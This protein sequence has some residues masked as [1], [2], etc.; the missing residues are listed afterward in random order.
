MSPS[1]YVLHISS[2]FTNISPLSHTSPSYATIPLRQTNIWTPKYLIMGRKQ[3]RYS[4]RLI[5]EK[6]APSLKSCNKTG[7][8]ETESPSHSKSSPTMLQSQFIGPIPLKCQPHE[9]SEY[10]STSQY[11]SFQYMLYSQRVHSKYFLMNLMMVKTSGNK[12]M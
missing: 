4:S 1:L 11:P 6:W 8:K 5:L 7:R 2:P 10:I 9:G 12:K 3:M